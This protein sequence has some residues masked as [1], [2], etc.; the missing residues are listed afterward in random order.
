MLARGW[1]PGMEELLLLMLGRGGESVNGGRGGSASGWRVATGFAALAT[2]AASGFGPWASGFCWGPEARPWAWQ[3]LQS[4]LLL[5]PAAPRRPPPLDLK[6]MPHT[7]ALMDGS[8]CGASAGALGPAFCCGG[9]AGGS[10]RRGGEAAAAFED[11]DVVDHV[12][13]ESEGTHMGDLC[14]PAKSGHAM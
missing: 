7:H 1:R 5:L 13:L 3:P 11:V 2:R 6:M 9:V 10:V 14:V 8:P 4:S 12:S